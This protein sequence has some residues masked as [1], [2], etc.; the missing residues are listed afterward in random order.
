VSTERAPAAPDLERLGSLLLEAGGGRAPPALRRL[1]DRELRLAL[2]RRARETRRRCLPTSMGRAQRRDERQE[3]PVPYEAHRLKWRPGRRVAV[4]LGGTRPGADGT[5][6]EWGWVLKCCRPERA[7]R[8]ATLHRELA[9]ALQRPGASA[10]AAGPA[11]IEVVRTDAGPRPLPRVPAIGFARPEAGWIALEAWPG[12]P[13]ARVRDRAVRDRALAAVALALAGLERTLEVGWLW[14]ARAWS[15]SREIDRLLEV[16]HP[17]GVPL[18]MDPEELAR[19][20]ERVSGGRLAPA[21]RDLYGEQIVVDPEAADL[22]A[23]RWVDWDEA[24]L[25]PAGLDLANLLAHEWLAG[26]RAAAPRPIAEEC[27]ALVDT[28]RSGGGQL[29]A[30]AILPWVAAACLRLAGIARQR[31][32]DDDPVIRS[33]GWTE[34][35]PL[36]PWEES[37]ALVDVALEIVAAA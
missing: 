22:G 23:E 4:L 18:P 5:V 11:R 25:A 21:H 3:V 17:T 14:P 10:P 31:A 16:W 2:I 9:R 26:L 19:L 32:R 15:I 1:L 28:Y 12:L 35:S 27:A 8:L 29:E 24:A 37:A 6:V 33:P 34:P 13:L 36:P 20:L 7:A 30:S